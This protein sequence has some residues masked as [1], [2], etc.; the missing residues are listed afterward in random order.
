MP[1]RQLRSAWP[2]GWPSVMSSAKESAPST[3]ETP[4]DSSPPGS[5][6]FRSERRMEGRDRFRGGLMSV[7]SAAGPAGLSRWPTRTGASADQAV[8]L[9]SQA[10]VHDHDQPG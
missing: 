7:F 1:I 4:T 2:N 8:V 5:T 6:I 3:S 9:H 10:V